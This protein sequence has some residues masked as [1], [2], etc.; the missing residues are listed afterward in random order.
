MTEEPITSQRMTFACTGG[1]F[2]APEHD[3]CK[4]N[5][6]GGPTPGAPCECSCHDTEPATRATRRRKPNQPAGDS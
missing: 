1:F 5:V 2:F 3:A 4:G 6:T